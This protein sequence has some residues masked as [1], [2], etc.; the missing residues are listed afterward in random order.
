MLVKSNR[1][2][3]PAHLDRGRCEFRNIKAIVLSCLDNGLYQLG[4]IHGILKQAYSRNQ[5][6]P[7]KEKFISDED[8]PKDKEVSL[9]TAAKEDSMG[10]GQGFFRCNCKTGCESG[11]CKCKKENVL[12]NSKCHS[13]PWRVLEG[14]SS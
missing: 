13:T 2:F 11:R 4:T 7:V 1:R 14:G 8:V 9:R 6:S 3:K 5:F 10:T 12:C